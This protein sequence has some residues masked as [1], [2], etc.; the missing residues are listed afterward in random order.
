SYTDVSGA[1]RWEQLE[2]TGDPMKSVYPLVVLLHGLQGTGH[3]MTNI[4]L[5]YDHT[6][7]I[8]YNVDRGWHAYPGVGIWSFAIDPPT[9]A[10]GWRT[11]LSQPA[12][13]NVPANLRVATISY[14]QI[15]A[16]GEVAG[17]SLQ[18]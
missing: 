2:V 5:L 15:D 6:T 3:D 18:L 4:G 10:D 7:P 9:Q 8:P 1:P 17:A 12:D 11:F 14:D 16:N 13:D